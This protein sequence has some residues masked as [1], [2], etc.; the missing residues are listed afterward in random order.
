MKHN[1]GFLKLFKNLHQILNVEDTKC[2]VRR[3][4]VINVSSG[5]TH[6]VFC[7]TNIC[8]FSPIYEDVIIL[9]SF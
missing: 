5:Q 2:R 7:N 3:E 8:V 6:V 4:Q 1:G 9:C